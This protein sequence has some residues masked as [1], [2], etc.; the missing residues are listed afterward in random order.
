MDGFELM[1]ISLISNCQPAKL[2]RLAEKSQ[3]PILGIRA[4]HRHDQAEADFRPELMDDDDF[5]GLSSSLML[6]EG[7]RVLLTHNLWVEAGLTNGALGTVVGF[8]WPEGGDPH[9]SDVAK[10]APY[11]VVVEFDDID[12]GSDIVGGQQVARNFFPELNDVLG[13]NSKGKLR[14]SQCVPIFRQSA[15]A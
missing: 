1:L 4:Y 3:V 15:T 10:K 11:C 6:C 5:Q 13:R 14:A 7:A 12:L 8:V 9:S 2:K